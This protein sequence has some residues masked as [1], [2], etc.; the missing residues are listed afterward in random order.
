MIL[1]PQQWTRGLSA[2]TLLQ[3]L[4]ANSGRTRL[5]GGAVRDALLG[6]PV[7]DIDL[8]TELPPHEVME[9]LQAAGV[10]AVPTGI[11]HGTITAVAGDLVAEV[12][13]LRRD[14]A[15]DGRHAEIAYTDDWQEDAARR[16]FT[17]NALNA[18]LPAGQVTDFFGGIEDLAARHVRFIGDPLIRI[19]EDH[20]RIL[21]F[22]RF[23]ARFA[24]GEPDAAGLSACI[25]RARDLMALSRERIAMELLK[26]LELENPLPTIRLMVENGILA[27]VL[28]EIGSA[29]VQSLSRLI[30]RE[31][32][33]GIPPDAIRRLSALLPQ[34]ADTAESVAQRLR[35]S[36]A[37]R[38]RMIAAASPPPSADDDIRALAFRQ[39]H[40]TATDRLLLGDGE[41]RAALS[42]LAEW[43]K[44]QLPISG[45]HLI[46]RGL[47]P[48]PVVSERLQAF[49]DLW[50]SEGF[51]TDPEI[52]DAL[53]DRI[54]AG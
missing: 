11:A 25:A 34:G 20:L 19:A 23:H 14:V 49:Q 13:T 44:P 54:L 1:P 29:G 38:S 7:S 46:A 27:S 52:I 4:D 43:Q 41:A 5:V 36:R 26:L 9:R 22:F 3:A 18:T 31:G 6:L 12:T 45:K 21:R 17:I 24:E 47:T 8:A 42:T 53:I 2:T 37:Q 30:E 15:T 16:D 28:P 33:Y 51:P 35:L 40:V 10:K 39:G 48:G 50:I 32:R